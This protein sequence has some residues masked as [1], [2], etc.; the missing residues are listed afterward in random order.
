MLLSIVHI[1]IAV[2]GLIVLF[3]AYFQ[4][5][6]LGKLAA[7]VILA[8]IFLTQLLNGF[9]GLVSDVNFLNFLEAIFRGISG[10]VVYVELALLIILIFF[11]KH[12]S[13]AE[14][15]KW[16]LVGYII[17]VLLLEFGVFK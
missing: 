14:I 13:K 17:L 6:T 1:V 8:A 12:K 4:N 5:N 9:A 15:L 16:S 7:F 11:T 10:L 2:L 3:F